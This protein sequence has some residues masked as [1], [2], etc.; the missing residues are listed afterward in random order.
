MRR[1]AAGRTRRRPSDSLRPVARPASCPENGGPDGVFPPH[2]RIHF[3]RDA[4]FGFFEARRLRLTSRNSNM[5]RKP[6]QG[7]GPRRSFDDRRE[8]SDRSDRFDRFDRSDR[9]DRSDRSDRFG[10][11]ERSDRTDRAERPNRFERFER[12]DRFERSDRSERGERRFG[13]RSDR[14]DRSER[15][16]R[17]GGDFRK[18]PRAFGKDRADFGQRSGPRARAFETRRFAERSDFAKQAV[19]KLDADI[20]DFFKSAEDVNKFL[21]LVLTAADLVKKPAKEEAETVTPDTAATLF[22]ETDLEDDEESSYGEGA[23]EA[24]AEEADEE[25]DAEEARE[26]APKAE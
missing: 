24:A 14:S 22:A 13:N 12:T 16:D 15:N 26:A 11:F 10:R 20:A 7:N 18:A 6:W 4:L 23:E 17:R 2:T 8:R 19:V 1:R 5:D 3:I 21:R 25:D 9:A